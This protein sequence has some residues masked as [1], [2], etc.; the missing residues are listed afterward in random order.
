M[1]ITCEDETNLLHIIEH[2]RLYPIIK[3]GAE[4]IIRQKKNIM[5]AEFGSDAIKNLE[6]TFNRGLIEIKII[7]K[8]S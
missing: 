7:W 4:A 8:I 1:R 2:G 5:K 6:V 3:E